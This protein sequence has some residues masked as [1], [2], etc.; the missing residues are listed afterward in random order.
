MKP[1]TPQLALCLTLHI[2]ALLSLAQSNDLDRRYQGFFDDIKPVTGLESKSFYFE[3][4]S[5]V[6]NDGLTLLFSS[7]RDGDVKLFQ[8]TRDSILEPFGSP[9]PVTSLSPPGWLGATPD[10]EFRWANNHLRIQLDE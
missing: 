1:T 7:D 6:S 3:F 2:T 8:A 5:D 9:E 4:P 10:S